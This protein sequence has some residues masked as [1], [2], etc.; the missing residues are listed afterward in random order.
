MP[1]TLE[2][3]N[4]GSFGQRNKFIK[5]RTTP[6]GQLT[7]GRASPERGAEMYVAIFNAGRL[8]TWRKGAAEGPDE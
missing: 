6:I 2:E 3:F 8:R 7:F 4:I 1:R 5:H